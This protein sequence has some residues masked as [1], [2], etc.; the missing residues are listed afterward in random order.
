MYPALYCAGDWVW[1]TLV[2]GAAFPL[3]RSPGRIRRKIFD[4]IWRPGRPGLLAG[5]QVRLHRFRYYFIESGKL[6]EKLRL[7]A[8]IV[9]P[10]PEWVSAFFGSPYRPWLKLKFIVNTFRSRLGTPLSRGED[11]HYQ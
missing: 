2:H 8:T 1:D 11:L 4:L 9:S 5:K 10:R 7:V 6:P 3:A